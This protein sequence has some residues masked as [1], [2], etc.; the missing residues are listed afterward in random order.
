MFFV[1][2]EVGESVRKIEKATTTRKTGDL[3]TGRW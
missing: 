2:A 1:E 3:F